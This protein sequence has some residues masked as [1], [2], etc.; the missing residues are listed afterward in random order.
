M[1]LTAS[2]DKTIIGTGFSERE[3]ELMPVQFGSSR[4]TSRRS[5]S[6][7]ESCTATTTLCPTS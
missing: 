1:I 2:R 3:G 4:A 5:G 7:S 6:P